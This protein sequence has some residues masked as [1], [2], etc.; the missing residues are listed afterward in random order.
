MGALG[1]MAFAEEVRILH[2][3]EVFPNES[4]DVGLH[5]GGFEFVHPE[6]FESG[7]AFSFFSASTERRRFGIARVLDEEKVDVLV[8][9]RRTFLMGG[10]E[11]I[12]DLRHELDDFEFAGVEPRF[13]ADF[14]KGGVFGGFVAFHVSFGEDVF[15]FPL[16]VLTAKKEH[17][18]IFRALPIYYSSGTFF[19]NPVHFQYPFEGFPVRQ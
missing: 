8:D 15:V 2:I 14:A 5:V 4:V 13:F 3:L 16:P 19:K 12:V 9:Y 10:D 18:D 7:E 6:P 17:L 1:L 11:G